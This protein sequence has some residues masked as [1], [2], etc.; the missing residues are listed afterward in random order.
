MA[1]KPHGARRAIASAV[2]P[3]AN[4]MNITSGFCARTAA[5]SRVQVS[6]A[7]WWAALQQNPAIPAPRHVASRPS[8]CSGTTSTSTPSPLDAARTT[9]GTRS[10]AAMASGLTAVTTASNPRSTACAKC[11]SRHRPAPRGN[12]RALLR[13]CATRQA[14]A[15]AF[16][17]QVRVKM[18]KDNG[19]RTHIVPPGRVTRDRWCYTAGISLHIWVAR[20]DRS[21]AGERRLAMAAPTVASPLP[22]CRPHRRRFGKSRPTHWPDTV[23][24]PCMIIS[25]RS[26]TS[27]SW[28]TDR[29]GTGRGAVRV[30]AMAGH[31]VAGRRLHEL[32]ISRPRGRKPR[33]ASPSRRH[34]GGTKSRSSNSCRASGRASGEPCWRPDDP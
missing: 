17:P 10:P 34:R 27:K 15:P 23:L 28:S 13:A 5:I 16:W 18:D 20:C 31:A 4:A 12:G 2:A 14:G 21:P 1:S 29:L 24:S 9:P 25:F 3:W 30:Q 32:E 6:G 7:R 19:G 22:A 11:G 26:K 33:R 8:A